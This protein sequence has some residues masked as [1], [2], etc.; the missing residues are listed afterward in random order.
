MVCSS[1]TPPGG[2]RSSRER[3]RKDATGG[4]ASRL[5]LSPQREAAYRHERDAD[6][7]GNVAFEAIERVFR[8]CP[9]DICPADSTSFL[10]V[11]RRAGP[12]H[13]G[14]AIPDS[15]PRESIAKNRSS[16]K[17]GQAPTA[18][19]FRGLSNTRH[20]YHLVA[21]SLNRN[22]PRTTQELEMCGELCEG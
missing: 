17:P 21:R 13:H 1:A 18:T 2:N 22:V 9:D 8:S 20:T 11:R 15:L 4:R 10:T 14:P 6:C 16:G 7:P 19:G 5:L 3:R 12:A